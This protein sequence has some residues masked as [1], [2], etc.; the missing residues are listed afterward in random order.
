M[1]GQGVGVQDLLHAL[2]DTT[3]SLYYVP[4]VMLSGQYQVRAGEV[5]GGV[6]PAA[7]LRSATLPPH[8]GHP[9]PQW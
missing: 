3:A 6:L 2:G 9:K 1:V 4:D 8:A 7:R 5:L